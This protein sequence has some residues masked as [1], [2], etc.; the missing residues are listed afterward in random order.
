M[1]AAPAPVDRGRAVPR[2]PAAHS[3]LTQAQNEPENPASPEDKLSRRLQSTAS[4]QAPPWS[5]SQLALAKRF[6]CRAANPIRRSWNL[7]LPARQISRGSPER[8][9]RK[10][11]RRDARGNFVQFPRVAPPRSQCCS[12]LHLP[13]DTQSEAL[14]PSD[15]IAPA[16]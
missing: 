14:R 5:T 6:C 9:W 13:R 8:C 7:Q 1:K 3:K 12:S 4:R 15:S 2:V 16:V 11:A 10:N